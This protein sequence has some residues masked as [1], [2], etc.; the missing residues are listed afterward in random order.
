MPKYGFDLEIWAAP[1]PVTCHQR[2]P[3]HHGL[4]VFKIAGATADALDVPACRSACLH[5]RTYMHMLAPCDVLI[6]PVLYV[7]TG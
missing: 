2:G 4:F 3:L 6:R 7:I 5:I 1:K